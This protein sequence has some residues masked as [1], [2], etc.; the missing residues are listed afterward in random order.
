MRKSQLRGCQLCLFP[1][2]ALGIFASFLRAAQQRIRTDVAIQLWPIDRGVANFK[3]PPLAP[4][5]QLKRGIKRQRYTDRATIFQLEREPI[6][7]NFHRHNVRRRVVIQFHS[8]YQ[9]TRFRAPRVSGRFA[10]VPTLESLCSSS[11]ARVRAKIWLHCHSYAHAHVPVRPAQNYRIQSDS[12]SRGVRSA[13]LYS[14][15]A[16]VP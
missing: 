16:W 5:C 9:A 3:I 7:G 15:S 11:T 6:V 1:P 12:L 13:R 10:G 2:C 4:G 8:T 14:T